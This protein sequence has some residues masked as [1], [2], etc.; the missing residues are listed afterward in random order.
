PSGVPDAFATP[1]CTARHAA[2]TNLPTLLCRK[3]WR[4]FG[5]VMVCAPPET[6]SAGAA[7][8]QRPAWLSRLVDAQDLDR[9]RRRQDFA[10]RM[11]PVAGLGRRAGALV[12]EPVELVETLQLD[13]EL[14]GRAAVA[15]GHRD[16]QPGVELVLA[17]RLDL[18]LDEFDPALAV[19]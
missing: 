9:R 17:R 16:Q 4:R 10:E 5:N 18:A 8:W 7:E 15:A 19:D 6:E 2:P 3:L 12:A 1:T 11:H 13:F 14:Q